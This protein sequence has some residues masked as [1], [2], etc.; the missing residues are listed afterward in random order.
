MVFELLV[1]GT[2]V[3][4]NFK[5]KKLYCLPLFTFLIGCG[6]NDTFQVME[7]A[8]ECSIVAERLGNY[9]ASNDII[10]YIN[11]NYP[12]SN[13]LTNYEILK[14]KENNIKISE[15]LNDQTMAGLKGE[16]FYPVK[17]FNSQ[18]CRSM[19]GQEKIDI[20]DYQLGPVGLIYYLFYFLI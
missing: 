14:L 11:E 17:T 3:L 9:T 20:K 12:D 16:L 4:N 6:S 13:N 19:H 8:I 1:E 15:K 5:F 10:D 7:D 18:T 2:I